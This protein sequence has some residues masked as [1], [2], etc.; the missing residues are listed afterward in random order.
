K[1]KL[2]KETNTVLA[3][4]DYEVLWTTYKITTIIGGDASVNQ[5]LDEQALVARYSFVKCLFN[6]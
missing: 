6:N 5:V 3:S 1:T 2:K 4:N